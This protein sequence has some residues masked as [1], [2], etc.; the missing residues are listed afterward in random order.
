MNTTAM[1]REEAIVNQYRQKRHNFGVRKP[2]PNGRSKPSH[3]RQLKNRDE[4]S[5]KVWNEQG[6]TFSKY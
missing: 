2:T 4:D 1:S 3:V 5:A 6:G